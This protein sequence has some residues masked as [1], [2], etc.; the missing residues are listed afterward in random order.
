MLPT[1]GMARRQEFGVD[2][3][4]MLG[5][6]KTLIYGAAQ[7]LVGV[8]PVEKISGMRYIRYLRLESKTQGTT[9][10]LRGGLDS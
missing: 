6:M 10:E 1:R 5:A 4:G 9:Q 3:C 2:F 7:E 8:T